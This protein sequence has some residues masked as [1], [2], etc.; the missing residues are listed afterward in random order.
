M[1]SLSPYGVLV[2]DDSASFRA[3][4]THALEASGEL[5]VIGQARNGRE[6]I[7]V[8][9]SLQN[10]PA[11]ITMDVVMPE[12]SGIDA[13]RY[14]M[15]TNPCPVVLLTTLARSEEQQVALHAMRLGVV[16]VVG[17]PSFAPGH[18]SQVTD[19]VR[20]VRAMAEV[21]VLRRKSAMPHAHN[22]P[23]VSSR[24][25]DVVAVATSTGGPP[26]LETVF[27]GLPKHFPPVVVAQ[28]L[29]QQF[30]QSFGRWLRQVSGRKVVIVEKRERLQPDVIYVAGEQVHLIMSL[31]WVEPVR[32]AP[33]MLAPDANMLFRSCASSY[34]GRA[35]GVVMTGMGRDGAEGLLAMKLSGAWT[36]G[37]DQATSVVYGMPRAAAEAGATCEVLPL[38]DIPVRL[39]EIC[40]GAGSS[41]G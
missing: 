3:L 31:G 34:A 29:A 16:D 35:V 30:S 2:V 15:E 19:L 26:A 17:K 37:Q 28:H 5:K 20:R 21:K 18:Q 33:G 14:I 24:E 23:T 41:G 22:L 8:L 13:T 6:A 9:E 11:V 7:S 36:I 39:V 25:V 12:M 10:K 38:D 40:A 32:S 4:L 27:A 1:S